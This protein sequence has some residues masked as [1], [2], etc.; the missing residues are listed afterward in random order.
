MTISV[1]GGA[2]WKEWGLGVQVILLSPWLV[3]VQC[4]PFYI[5]LEGGAS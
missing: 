2:A 1:G 4:G 3:Q 5:Y